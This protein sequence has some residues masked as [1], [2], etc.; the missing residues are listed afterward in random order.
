MGKIQLQPQSTESTEV[1][2]QLMRQI[3]DLKKQGKKTIFNS[4]A[5]RRQKNV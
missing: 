2:E 4:Q 5:E 3:A 1:N